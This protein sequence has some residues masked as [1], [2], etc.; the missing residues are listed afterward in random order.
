MRFEVMNPD[1]EAEAA[2]DFQGGK[3]A[4]VTISGFHGSQTYEMSE[5]DHN[6]VVRFTGVTEWN[7]VPTKDVATPE[8][9]Q[10][11]E[12]QAQTEAEQKAAKELKVEAPEETAAEKQQREAAERVA[13]HNDKVKKESEKVDHKTP[14][15]K[16]ENPSKVENKS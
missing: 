11:E 4:T 14:A 1:G 10:M 15:Q 5:H 6:I 3:G 7:S 9:K 12:K 8:Q 13:E 16:A 2:F